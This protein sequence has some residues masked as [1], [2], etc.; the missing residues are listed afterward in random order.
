MQLNEAAV[1]DHVTI[2]HLNVSSDLLKKRLLALG[3]VEGCELCIKQKG[4]FS[5]SL[6]FRNKG[7]AH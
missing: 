1:G 2:T 5:W 3:C 6:Y 7:A 4:F